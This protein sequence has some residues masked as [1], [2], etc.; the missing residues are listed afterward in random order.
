MKKILLPFVLFCL[1]LHISA[2]EQSFVLP[3]E[4]QDYNVTLTYEQIIQYCHLVDSLFDEVQY[5]TF[6]KSAQGSDLPYLLIDNRTKNNNKITLW[7]QAG[8]HPGE[9]EGVEAGFLFIRDVLTYPSLKPLLD[10]VR[11]VFIPSFN[12]DG[13]KRFGPYN[14]INQNGPEQ[15]G[16]RTTA[17][18]LNLNRD[19]MKADAP[20]MQAW[21]KLYNSINPDFLIDCHTTDGADYVYPLTY[22]LDAFQTLDSSIASW[23][24]GSYVPFVTDQMDRAGF[25]IYPYVAFRQWHNPKSGLLSY[26]SRPMLSHGYTLLTDRPCLL[27]E[28]HM[29][30]PYKIRVDATQRMLL[31]TFQ[32]LAENADAYSAMLEKADRDRV[33]DDFI[34]RPFPISLT[35]SM[36]DSVLVEFNG[37]KYDTIKSKTT[38]G[39][40]YKYD[41]TKPEIWKIQMFNKIVV[42]DSIS[43]PIAYVVPVE[44]ITVIDRLQLHGISII[45][46][47]DDKEVKCTASRLSGV[48]F[49][50]MSYEGCFRPDFT[51]S[52]F[53]TI[54]VIPRNSALVTVKQSKI[55]VL[56]WLLD[57]RSED[58]FLKWGFFNT[59]FEQKEYGEMYVLEPLADEMFKKDKALKA[60]FEALKKNDPGF[61]ASQWA[62]MNWIYNHT[63]WRD[64][65]MNVYPVVKITDRNEYLKL[66]PS[67]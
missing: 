13:L 4:T 28:T 49:P 7:I 19:F 66:L 8:I 16:W 55:K 11:I 21:L 67:K 3:Y 44:W 57:A 46:T 36:N 10:K 18:N 58:S 37:M 23:C 62:Q 14:R 59:I 6:G 45:R 38:G 60:E 9:P 65:K 52:E 50:A 47:A 40:Y 20:E 41:N 17:Q 2:Q 64:Q 61:A 31:F 54:M 42:D 34:K 43:L 1:T 53:D 26:A 48:S 24:T 51:I 27:I 22:G 35:T 30:K 63:A 15:M 56:V 33:L 32:Y 39:I 12:V 5:F 29:L 25:P